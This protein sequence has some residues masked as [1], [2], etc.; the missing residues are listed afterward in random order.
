MTIETYLS[1]LADT[2]WPDVKSPETRDPA[3]RVRRGQGWRYWRAARERRPGVAGA[4]MVA[5]ELRDQVELFLLE[6]NEQAGI[7][8]DKP[9][10]GVYRFPGD[11]EARNLAH[12]KTIDEVSAALREAAVILGAVSEKLTDRWSVWPAVSEV[13]QS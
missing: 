1:N 2:L 5:Q 11:V 13:D 9:N 6:L 10:T 7:E 12:T 3:S 8:L 4:H